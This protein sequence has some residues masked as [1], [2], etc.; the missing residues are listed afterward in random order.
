MKKNGITLIEL[1]TTMLIAGIIGLAIAAHF[2]HEYRFRAAARDRIAFSREAGIAMNHITRVLRF[3]IPDTIETEYE[4][5]SLKKIEA[6][7]EGGHL[8]LT[9][10][11]EKESI[12]YQY[13]P[14]PGIITYGQGDNDAVELATNIIFFDV[15][16]PGDDSQEAEPELKIRLTAGNADGSISIPLVTTIRVLPE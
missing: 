11:V 12:F 2:I 4:N 15:D 1:I 6:D 9:G 10:T 8:D 13:D 7:I 16:W 14:G 3:A 5:D